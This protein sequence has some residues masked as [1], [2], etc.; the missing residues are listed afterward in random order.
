MNKKQAVQD[1]FNKI[2]QESPDACDTEHW[3]MLYKSIERKA[4]MNEDYELMIAFF[5]IAS[6]QEEMNQ[7]HEGWRELMK[8]GLNS[9][10]RMLHAQEQLRASQRERQ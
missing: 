7:R 3:H 2:K 6:K 5:R 1:E 10:I 8:K 9:S 4:S